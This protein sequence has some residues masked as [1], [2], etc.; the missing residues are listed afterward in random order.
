[1]TTLV[2]NGIFRSPTGMKVMPQSYLKLEAI[3]SELRPSLPLVTGEQFMLDCEA[4]FERTLP[5]AG[6]QYRVDEINEVG[7]CAGYTIPDLRVVALRADVYEKLQQGNV[8][9]R[10]TVVH[11]FSHIALRHHLTLYRGVAI[12]KHEFYE[13]SEW[14]A[15]ATTAAIMMP[16]AAARDARS[17]VDFAEMCGTSVTAATFRIKTL[18]KQKLLTPTHYLWEYA[19]DK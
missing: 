6:Y 1:M 18:V 12:D 13:D 10:S 3:A 7:E 14:Q 19:D 5:A 17:P 15:K 4:I 2:T 11:E 8:Y 16:L 9:G